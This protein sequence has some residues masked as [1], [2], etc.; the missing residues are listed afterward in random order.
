[1]LELVDGLHGTG[2][3]GPGNRRLLGTARPP[4][5]PLHGGIDPDRDITLGEGF[6]TTEDAQQAIEQFVDRT[7]AD[8][9][10]WHLHLFPQRGK[11]T[12]PF[13]ILAQ[14]TEAGTARGH[15]AIF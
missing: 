3:Q 8:S 2:L 5:G 13:E 9:F 15:R 11:E 6:G 4:K 10:L 7:I 14:G 12:L 1:V